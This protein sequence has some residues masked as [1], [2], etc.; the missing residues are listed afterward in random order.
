MHMILRAPELS[1]TSRTVCIWIIVAPSDLRLLEHARE[2]PPLVARQ[3][4]RLFDAHL[5]AD[6][7]LVLLV[8]DLVGLPRLQDLLVLAMLDLPI[9]GDDDGLHHLVADDDALA[10]LP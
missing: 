1:A 9:D 2:P 4:A 3:R 5:V 6:L 7:A 8:V 10:E